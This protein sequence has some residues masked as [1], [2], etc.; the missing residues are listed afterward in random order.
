MKWL[1]DILPDNEQ[2]NTFSKSISSMRDSVRDS[3]VIGNL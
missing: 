2:W 3:I 1:E